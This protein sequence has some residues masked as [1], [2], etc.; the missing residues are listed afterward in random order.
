M[1]AVSIKRS[2]NSY[3]WDKENVSCGVPQ[4]SVL[5]P[6]VFLLYV[7]D[8]HHCCNKLKFLLFADNNVVYPVKNLKTL[9]SIVKTALHN[10]FNWRTSSK[11]KKSNFVIFR[12]HQKKLNY[13]SQIYIFDNEKHKIVS[14]EQKNYIVYLGLLIDG[15][16]SWKQHICSLTTKI[17][18]VKLLVSNCEVTAYCSCNSNPSWYH[19]TSLSLHLGT[20]P[21]IMYALISW[22]MHLRPLLIK[23]LFFKKVISVLYTLLK[24]RNMQYLSS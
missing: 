11:L 13:Q 4:G 17:S 19:F 23:F 2:I 10:L 14:L 9:D 15:N 6:L 24:Q 18:T 21:C 12:P 8:I 3:I 22:A 20:R 5:G 7:I 16:L 1:A